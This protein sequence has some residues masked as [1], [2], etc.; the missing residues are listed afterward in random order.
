MRRFLP[1]LFALTAMVMVAC[2][3]TE[4]TA[5]PI[6]TIVNGDVH[7]IGAEG[8]SVTV[9][10]F[11]ENHVGGE[12]V[13]W[14]ILNTTM[15]TA[16]DGSV[17]G[18]IKIDVASNPT[19]EAR[20]GSIILSYA[21]H[22]KNITIK[23]AAG[24]EPANS[25]GFTLLDSATQSV[26]AEG[27]NIMVRYNIAM[28]IEGETVE[29]T[30]LN[31]V[32]IPEV[33]DSIDGVVMIGVAPNSELEP[34]TGEVILAY[35]DVEYT[36]TI[37]Q[38]AAAYREVDI[39]ANQLI[40]TYYG[41]RVT[42]GL[43]NYWLIFSKDGVEGGDVQP[44]TEFIRLDILAPL[45]TSEASVKVP[46]GTYRF[47]ASNSCGNY[48]ILNLPNSDYMYVDE[49]LEGWSSQLTGATMTVA[50]NRIVVKAY[51]N[52]MKINLTFDGDYSLDVAKMSD[53]ISNLTSDLAIDV[54]DCDLT[55]DNYGDYWHCGYC[56]WVVEFIKMNGAVLTKYLVLD[57]LGTTPDAS[58]GYARVY[59]SAGF[60]EEDPSKPNFG[61]GVF[62][63]CTR[64]SD[65]GVYMQGS[66][67]MVYSSEGKVIT[68]APITTGTIELR[69]NSN[70]TQ[71]IIVDAYDDAPE[72]HKITFNWTGNLY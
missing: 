44:N 53:C 27:G 29:C 31:T 69:D 38:A 54:S 35:A 32:M 16:V 30:I 68:Q 72:P 64:I 26:E 21:G 34:R 3:N 18:V 37:T 13:K 6:F 63:P 19:L 1:Y 50:G 57:L 70:G 2:E 51:T 28:P 33:N 24:E 42:E 58:S 40:G 39:A 46:D 14:E 55:F 25:V 60:S 10:Y 59:P 41:E 5:E 67:Y 47:D 45:A 11:I 4:P 22:N 71:S 9:N 62:V 52:T 43:G 65:D 48:S 36:I 7:N 49:N 56:N 17:K 8:G 12:E 61:P 20:E 23:Q 66:M 15:I